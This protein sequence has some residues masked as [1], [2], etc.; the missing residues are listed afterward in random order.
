MKSKTQE[1]VGLILDM[2]ERKHKNSFNKIFKSITMDNGGEF[3]DQASIEKSQY[4]DKTR[5][6][7]FYAHPF[8]AWERGSNENTN[9]IIRR[10]IPKGSNIANYSK[11]EIE[12]IQH[13]I[14]NYP[15]RILGYRTALEVY[16][17]A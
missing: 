2:L 13:W 8:S 15:R 16:Q 1:E 7:V 9:K 17:A 6:T 5:T 11:K 14:N 4:S 10:F 12:R 3:L